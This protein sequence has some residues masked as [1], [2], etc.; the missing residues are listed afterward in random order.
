MIFGGLFDVVLTYAHVCGLHHKISKDHTSWQGRMSARIRYAAYA[1]EQT[2]QAKKMYFLC[3]C[4]LMTD[5]YLAFSAAA[6]WEL[7]ASM[8]CYNS[9][10]CLIYVLRSMVHAVLAC[11]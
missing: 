3:K 6:A 10:L 2:Q 9:I 5:V 7:V 1:E 8:F 4:K 11:W